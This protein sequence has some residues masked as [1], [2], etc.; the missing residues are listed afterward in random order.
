[1]SALATEIPEREDLRLLLVNND[2]WAQRVMRQELEML[3]GF[4]IV[5]EGAN[6]LEAIRLASSTEPDVV[7][8]DDEVAGEATV[9]ILSSILDEAPRTKV[10]LLAVNVR[11]QNVIRAL[12]A[13]AVGFLSKDIRPQA[14]SRT[15]RGVMLGEA[16]ISR[17][18]AAHILARAREEP[19]PGRGMRPVRSD[20][21]TRE[22]EVYDLVSSGASK[23]DVAR[24]LGLTAGTVRSHLRN[25]TRKLAATATT[26][27]DGPHIADA[28]PGHRAPHA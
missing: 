23:Q 24:E 2:P 22:W 3:P 5:G 17:R 13:G 11:E 26:D 4:V 12:R 20:L 14:L 16:A 18:L 10:V 9:Q 21:T 27:R 1:M 7:L 25:L 19:R 15:L 6:A 8:L 28:R